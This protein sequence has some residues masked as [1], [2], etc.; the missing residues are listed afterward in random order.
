MSE[1]VMIYIDGSNLYHSLKH[2]LQRTDLDFGKFCDKL[3][4]GRRLVRIYYYNAPV[5]QT[6]EPERYKD[7]QRFFRSMVEV[8]YLELRLGRLVYGDWPNV[9]PYEKGI[10]VKLATDLLNHAFRGNYDVAILVS[11]DND[12]VDALQAVKD[13]GKNV[14]VALFGR[15]SSQHLRTVADKVI[16]LAPVFLRECWKT[17]QGVAEQPLGGHH[18]G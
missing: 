14:E 15:R 2:Q 16:E 13:L 10:D 5:D 1:R 18:P 9:S 4:A 6:K 11:G 8:P 7:Q 3:A 12:F 17:T